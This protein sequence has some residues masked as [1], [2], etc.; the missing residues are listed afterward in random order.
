MP[1]ER[2]KGKDIFK[3]YYGKDSLVGLNK[4]KCLACG[5]IRTQNTSKGYTNLIDHVS[6]EHAEDYVQV[7]EAY[8]SNEKEAGPLDCFLVKKISDKAK[9]IHDWLE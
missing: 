2:F 9:R 5:N 3:K 6:S 1:K 8:M 7:M 4:H